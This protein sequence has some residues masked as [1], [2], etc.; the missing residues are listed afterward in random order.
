MAYSNNGNSNGNSDMVRIGGL[1]KNKTKDG[2]PYLGGS[3][4]G[5]R[6]MVFQNGYKEKDSDP[7][8]VLCIAQ[9]QKKEKEAPEKEEIPF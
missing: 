3:F 6:L 4:G 9:A 2:K 8:Y 5:A 1:W 7:D